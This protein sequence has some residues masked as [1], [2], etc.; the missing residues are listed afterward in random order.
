MKVLALNNKGGLSYC[1]VAP[2]L[3]GQGRC[4]HLEHQEEN[5]SVEDFVERIKQE[6]KYEN[7]KREIIDTEV[8]IKSYRMSEEEKAS[9]VK[10]EGRKQLEDKD[11]QGG[12]IDLPEPLWNDTDKNEFSNISGLSVQEIN[13]ILNGEKFIVLEASE[14]SKY[15]EGQVVDKKK[16][17]DEDYETAEFGQGVVSLNKFAE[18]FNYKATQSVYVL[19]YSMRQDPPGDS[20][21]NPL[22]TLYNFLIYN[23]KNPDKQ[24][25]AYESLLNNRNSDNPITQRG[26]YAIDSLVD[27]LRGKS[28]IMRGYMSGRD[29]LNS[30]RAVLSL[31]ADMEYGYAKLP[32]YIACKIYKDSIIDKLQQNGM[33]KE[34]IDKFVDKFR[35]EQS[36][37]AKEDVEELN[38]VVKSL[39][40]RCILNRQPTLHE[41]SLISFKPLVSD[42]A[43]I[44]VS[45]VNFEGYNADQDGDTMTVYAINDVHISKQAE[46]FSANS[47][48]A[49]NLP[50]HQETTIV[51]P[52][53][54][55]M[56]GLMNILARRK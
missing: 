1:T 46:S 2:E 26:G 44:K 12:Y 50:R 38:K 9:L 19:P 20:G 56:W 16:L 22:N 4:N 35:D 5:E 39:G 52:S 36:S 21:K 54:E 51:R 13:K 6:D 25:K 42:T 41:A 43:T 31:D 10:I 40:L 17:K 37:I 32:P 8:E 14:S 53:K 55:A 33:S 27:E 24:Q 11:N 34:D 48:S 15:K 23:R 7:Y 30:G 47:S 28:G 18:K 3:R 45:P 29:I 49:T